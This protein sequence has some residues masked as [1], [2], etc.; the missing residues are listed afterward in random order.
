MSITSVSSATHARSPSV[1]EADLAQHFKAIGTALQ[2]GNLAGAKNAVSSFDQALQVA[3]AA[4]PA[5]PFGKNSQA[6]TDYQNLTSDLQTG[7]LASAQKDFA[8]LQNDLAPATKSPHSPASDLPS[9]NLD[10]TA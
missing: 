8:S 10:L 3:S 7:N 5:Q 9:G 6:N 1:H 4:S 2:S